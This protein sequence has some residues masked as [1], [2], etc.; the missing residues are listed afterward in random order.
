MLSNVIT[1]VVLFVDLTATAD[2]E[3]TYY[4]HRILDHVLGEGYEENMCAYLSVTMI[5]WEN[6]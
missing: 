4:Y 1:V 2:S 3:S 5:I 6:L